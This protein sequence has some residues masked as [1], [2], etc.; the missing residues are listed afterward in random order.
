MELPGKRIAILAT[1]GFEQSELEVPRDTLKQAG[2]TME[3]VSLQAGEIKGKKDWG[4]PVRSTGRSIK[5][6]L[7]TMT[8]SFCLVA[9]SIPIFC[10]SNPKPFN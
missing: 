8:P 4:R 2:A 1:N 3:I 5:C 9:K 10:A 7:A 6:P